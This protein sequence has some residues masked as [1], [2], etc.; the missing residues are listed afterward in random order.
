[1]G[2]RHLTAL[3]AAFVALALAPFVAPPTAEACGGFACSGA[4]VC[5][6][7]FCSGAPTQQS[8][9]NILF[10]IEDDGTL[11]VHIQIFYQGASDAFGWIL[12][13]PNVP[14]AIGV[15]T[16]ALFA[17]LETATMPRFELDYRQEGTCRDRPMCDRPDSGPASDGGVW[18]AASD[19]A[20]EGDAG[21]GPMIHLREEVGPYDAV[22]LSGDSADVVLTWLRDNDFDVPTAAEPLIADYVAA[23]HVFVAIRLLGGRDAGEIQPLTLRYAEGQPCVPIRLTAIAATLDMPITAYF[24]A[25]SF[26]APTNYSVVDPDFVEPRLWRGSLA[27]RDYVGRLIDDAGGQAFVTDY[28]GAVPSIFLA[29]PELDGLATL[30]DPMEYLQSLLGRGF[31][32]DPQLLGL[33]PR[34]LPVPEGQTAQTYYNCLSSPFGGGDSESCGYTGGFDPVAFTA[35][36]DEQVLQPRR[37]AQAMLARHS[38]LTRLYTTMDPSE[39]SLDP[40]FRLDTGLPAVS[41]VHTAT[42]VTECS[43]EYYWGEAPLR[44]DMPNGASASWQPGTPFRPAAE[45]CTAN[46]LLPPGTHAAA[47]AASSGSACTVSHGT[48]SRAALAAIGLALALALARRRRTA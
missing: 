18:W 24:L 30:T 34:F 11:T 26:V 41:N 23:R 45:W 44:L 14:T 2:N 37:D 5:T 16:D 17:Q 39:M 48:T 29:I 31:M 1:M 12:P 35:A 36:I 10:S 6:G 15:G 13:L 8:G 32:N 20:A 3:V 47:A 40:L 33:L 21:S 9:E 43:D 7:L 38:R 46:Y 19:A 27:Y 22:V 4:P 25:D 42:V 28:A